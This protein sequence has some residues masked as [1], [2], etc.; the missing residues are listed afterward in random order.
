MRST[1]GPIGRRFSF[2]G[3]LLRQPRISGH[4]AMRTQALAI[5]D[6]LLIVPQRF[7]D[8]RG[9]LGETFHAARLAQAGIPG[10]F[11]QENQ[12]YSR[13]KGTVRGLHFQTAPSA[14]G[15]LVRCVRGAIH[16]VA[17]DLRRGS[18]TYGQHVSAVLTAEAGEQMW[19]PVGFAHGF[20]TLEPDCEVVYK[21]TAYYDP[22]CEHGIAFDDPDLNIR[23][24]VAPQDAILSDKDRR[25]EAFA[26]LPA[27]F[28]AGS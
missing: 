19:V 1:G 21:L 24:P 25:N 16:D 3:G 8:S 4:G 22:A 17:V 13:A 10:P 9:Y 18:P 5:P 6:V 11:I 23:W 27:Y 20:C 26:N 14:Q 28:S 2:A 12:S 7:P 15:K